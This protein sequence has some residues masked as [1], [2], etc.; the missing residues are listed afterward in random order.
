LY[1]SVLNGIF[2]F[3]YSA[4]F[5]L[6]QFAFTAFEAFTLIVVTPLAY[7]LM[8]AVFCL[9]TTQILAVKN[10]LSKLFVGAARSVIPIVVTYHAA[11]Y[12]SLL[13]EQAFQ[14]PLMLADPF[15]LGWIPEVSNLR[16]AMAW[17]FNPEW[18]WHAQVLLILAG[19]AWGG[20]MI[21]QTIAEFSSTSNR[22]RVAHL[23]ALL[24]MVSLTTI[25][26]WVL[27]LPINPNP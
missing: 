19:H 8:F 5:K 18:V 7:I 4:D 14:F 10:Q 9:A 16:L 25:G 27:S 3:D 24:L 11:H 22:I 12:L 17:T 15:G 21:H 26:L 2:G 6:L 20:V 1:Q 13:G 23:G